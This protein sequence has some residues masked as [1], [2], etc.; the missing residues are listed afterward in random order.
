MPI[1]FSGS[2]LLSSFAFSSF[3]ANLAD[4]PSLGQETIY[5]A[6]KCSGAGRPHLWVHRG[7][8]NHGHYYDEMPPALRY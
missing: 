8:T 2:P 6:E 7:K 5:M 3:P 1:L 4:Y